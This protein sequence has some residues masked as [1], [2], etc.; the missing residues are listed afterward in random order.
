MKAFCI[1]IQEEE[2]Y[3]DYEEGHELDLLITILEK[4]REKDTPFCIED[5]VEIV[6]ILPDFFAQAK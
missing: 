3:F 2:Y 4:A 1:K 6:K 5:V